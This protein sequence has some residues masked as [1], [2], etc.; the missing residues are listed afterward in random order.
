MKLLGYEQNFYEILKYTYLRRDIIYPHPL[1]LP[2][3]A[4]PAAA[5]QEGR[6]TSMSSNLGE[7]TK[8]GKI[9]LVVVNRTPG[10][11]VSKRPLFNRPTS[12]HYT[13]VGNQPQ[14]KSGGVLES[15]TL[16]LHDCTTSQIP[17]SHPCARV[18]LK[19]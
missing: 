18:P 12:G 8:L 14:I 4:A 17:I 5:Q 6:R 2:I 16:A 3:H 19:K 10:M 9:L 11:V 13:S 15:S 1:H 7:L